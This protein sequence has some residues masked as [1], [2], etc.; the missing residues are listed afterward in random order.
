MTACLS[1]GHKN[2]SK[3]GSALKLEQILS[4]NPLYTG[5]LF[6]CYMLAESSCHFRSVWHNMSLLFYCLWKI[7]LANT[8]DP[9]QTPHYVVCDLGLPC[10]PMVIY[11]FPEKNGSRKSE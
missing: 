1:T 5:R 11:G 8:V 3:R 7:L 9:D 4:F 6:N 10:L 2:P